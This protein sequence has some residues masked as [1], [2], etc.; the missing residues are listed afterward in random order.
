MILRKSSRLSVYNVEKSTA[1]AEAVLFFPEK[2]DI[3]P[4][5]SPFFIKKII[6]L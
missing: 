2:N 4:K 5:Q 3:S 6:I 1:R